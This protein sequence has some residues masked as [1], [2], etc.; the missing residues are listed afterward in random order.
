MSEPGNGCTG[1]TVQELFMVEKISE[2]GKGNFKKSFFFMRE[3]TVSSGTI[4]KFEVKRSKGK[5]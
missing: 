3:A 5:T 4:E 2:R 1:I